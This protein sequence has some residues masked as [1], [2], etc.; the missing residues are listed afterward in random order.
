MDIS[1]EKLLEKMEFELKKARAAKDTVQIKGHIYA[2]KA[3]A[4]LM[5]EEEKVEYKEPSLP[6]R[7]PL[8]PPS[9]PVISEPLQTIHSK[10]L[11][12]EDGANGNSLFDF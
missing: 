5:L 7:Q 6:L 3:L 10:P 1:Y 9:S 8:V 11:E 12:T 4:E 2:L